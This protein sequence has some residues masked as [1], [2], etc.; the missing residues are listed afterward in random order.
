MA[1]ILYNIII[2]PIELVVEMVFEL[3]WRLVG[4]HQTNQ[5]LAVIGVS[6]AISLHAAALPPCGRGSAERA[7]HSEKTLALGKPHKK[8]FQRRRAFYD[9]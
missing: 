3:M 2:S 8:N 7:R 1:S 5:G 6:V 4:Q 9:A